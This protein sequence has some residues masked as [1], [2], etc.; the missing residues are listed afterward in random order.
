QSRP[1][2]GL[3]SHSCYGRVIQFVRLLARAVPFRHRTATVRERTS[4]LQH[5]VIHD[6]FIRVVSDC[7]GRKKWQT[8]AVEYSNNRKDIP[9]LSSNG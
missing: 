3:T 4:R 5:Q 7:L 2:D 1:Q 8:F 9:W 6:F